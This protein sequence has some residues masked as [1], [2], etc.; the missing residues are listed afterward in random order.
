MPFLSVYGYSP[1]EILT[2]CISHF[3]CAATRDN[4][5]GENCRG[6]RRHIS[7]FRDFKFVDRQEFEYSL[8]IY[9]FFIFLLKS[10]YRDRLRDSNEFS[11]QWEI[12]SPLPLVKNSK[13]GGVYQSNRGISIANLF[14]AAGWKRWGVDTEFF[15]SWNWI[16]VAFY[17]FDSPGLFRNM[18]EGT[19][20]I[21]S[22]ATIN[23][24]DN[25]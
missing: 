3:H 14:R 8:F 9:L 16:W 4:P 7:I 19:N 6:R 24:H 18:I 20:E 2:R 23:R 11:R 12:F 21:E 25:R 5:V 22:R 10:H 15:S 13:H 1:S 17:R